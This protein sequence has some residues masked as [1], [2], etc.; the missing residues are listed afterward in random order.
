MQT[1]ANCDILSIEGWERPSPINHLNQIKIM[2]SQLFKNKTT[3][4]IVIQ[5]PIMDIAN[6]EELSGP[7]G[8]GYETNYFTQVLIDEGFTPEELTDNDGDKFVGWSKKK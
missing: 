5:V 2:T 6:Y 8:R 7:E 4:E 1:V 3:N